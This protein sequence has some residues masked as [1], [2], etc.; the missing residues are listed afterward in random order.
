MGLVGPAC[1]YLKTDN[2]FIAAVVDTWDQVKLSFVIDENEQFSLSHLGK[3]V[4]SQ[5]LPMYRRE[6]HLREFTCFPA[7]FVFSFL[8]GGATRCHLAVVGLFFLEVTVVSIRRSIL[9]FLFSLIYGGDHLFVLFLR[10][11]TFIVQ[12][13]GCSDC[14]SKTIASVLLFIPNAFLDLIDYLRS[15]GNFHELRDSK[16]RFIRKSK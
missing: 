2:G 15:Y 14:Y 4:V 10:Y 1:A 8:Y 13:H 6:F 16:G 5:F 7:W 11:I 9:G 3:I 12:A